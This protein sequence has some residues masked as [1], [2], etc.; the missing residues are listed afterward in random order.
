MSTSSISTARS[1][2]RKVCGGTAEIAPALDVL[3]LAATIL[4]VFA[5]AVIAY[6]VVPLRTVVWVVY[7]SA[8][9]NG[10]EYLGYWI[11]AFAMPLFFLIAGVSAAPACAVKSPREFIKHRARRFL[12]PMAFCCLTILPLGY[13]IWAY[14][15]MVTERI[16]VSQMLRLRFDPE[17]QRHLFGPGHLWFLEYMFLL[18]VIWCL[19]SRLFA[20][21]SARASRWTARVLASPLRPLW[22]AV[23]TGLISYFDSDAF[24]RIS[25]TFVPDPVRLLH[26]TLFFAAGAWISKLPDPRERLVPY[27]GL[28][29]ALSLALFVPLAPLMQRHMAAPLAG[30]ELV[31]LV[32]L[33]SV[34]AWLTLFGT[35]G[36]AIRCFPVRVAW[37]RYPL[38]A[39]FWI[40]LFHLPMVGLMHVLL[41]PLDWP[42]VVKFLVTA[43]VALA[44]SFASYEYLVRYSLIG[45]L[46]NGARKRSSSPG[47]WRTEL[48]WMA[49]ASAVLLSLGCGCWYLRGFL[50]HDNF[51]EVLPGQVYRSARLTSPK[52]AAAIDRQRLRSVLTVA[53][54]SEAQDWFVEQRRLCET[55]GVAIYS[56]DLRPDSM[57]DPDLLRQLVAII[58]H[59]PRPLLIE[60]KWGISRA[61]LGSAVAL[62][63][64]GR[65]PDEALRQF[66]RSYGQLGGIEHTELA[67]IV[68]R[69]GAWL[70]EHGRSHQKEA[71]LAWAHGGEG[72]NSP[73]V[74]VHRDRLRV[75]VGSPRHPAKLR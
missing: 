59:A 9:S 30:G 50:F 39:S 58:E 13:A 45:E 41:L 4:V 54:G 70:A 21:L 2:E 53:G 19:L 56:L 33:N 64:A 51:H 8:V 35:L 34:V 67:K 42:A 22:L 26:Y 32:A 60:G 52:L 17:L 1:A 37:M 5:H 65:A 7:D 55:R 25:N 16:D 49:A 74:P 66:D 46:V 75:V 10:L 28:Y 48:G 36:L 3:R 23:P 57:P 15:L 29:A 40:Y 24:I 47:R 43:L 38:E 11:N 6:T 62:L 69:Y 61:G 73:Y 44:A 27:S 68:A 63:L 72:S 71:F 18:G 12:R 20:P 14:G 31:L